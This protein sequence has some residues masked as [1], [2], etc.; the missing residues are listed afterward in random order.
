MLDYP[1]PP[2]GPILN[3][4]P[5]GVFSE[6]TTSTSHQNFSLGHLLTPGLRSG[7]FKRAPLSAPSRGP[8]FQF[9]E[10]KAFVESL[11]QWLS[12]E[13]YCRSCA[14]TRPET[15][16]LKMCSTIRP[17]PG[18]HC[19]SFTQV[20]HVFGKPRQVALTR[21]YFRSVAHTRLEM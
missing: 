18:V 13:L 5:I 9:P 8:L 19:F 4:L 1:A 20:R 14:Q 10:S 7:G 6:S 3:S 16:R 17:L 21:T 15:W 11:D 12:P 2:R